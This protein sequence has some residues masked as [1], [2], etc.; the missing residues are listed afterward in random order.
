MELE[1]QD[2]GERAAYAMLDKAGI[3][4]KITKDGIRLRFGERGR[5][6]EPAPRLC[7]AIETMLA[8]GP[9]TRVCEVMIELHL[10]AALSLTP[11][12]DDDVC[13]L[14]DDC[15]DMAAWMESRDE[16]PEPPKAGTVLTFPVID[17]EKTDD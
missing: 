3:T 5:L 6:T 4:A 9:I 8:E 14:L 15:L 10:A 16:N 13:E 12:P 11:C 1:L 17:G 2:N 7:D